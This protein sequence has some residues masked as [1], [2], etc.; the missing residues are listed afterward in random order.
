MCG[1]KRNFTMQPFVPFHSFVGRTKTNLLGGAEKK[2]HVNSTVVAAD[3]ISMLD[4][5]QPRTR[6]PAAIVSLV[7]ICGNTKWDGPIVFGSVGVNFGGER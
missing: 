1:S 3:G 4:C 5:G 2:A 7:E 6:S